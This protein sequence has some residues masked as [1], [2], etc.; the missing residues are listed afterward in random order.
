MVIVANVD[1]S[2]RWEN[3]ELV[4]FVFAIFRQDPRKFDEFF[5]VNSNQL[6][7]SDHVFLFLR[8][9]KRNLNSVLKH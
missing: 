7:C 6:R 4:P 9:K 8:V 3:D 1:I 5:S 2:R